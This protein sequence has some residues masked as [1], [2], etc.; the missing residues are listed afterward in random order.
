M[1]KLSREGGVLRELAEQPF[2][3]HR[4]L[5][6]TQIGK[7]YRELGNWGLVVWFL[8]GRVGEEFRNYEC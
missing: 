6:F 5:R 1:E 8:V 3:N 2:F 7:E 4:L